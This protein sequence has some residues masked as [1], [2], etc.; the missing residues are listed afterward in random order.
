M[1]KDVITIDPELAR[2]IPSALPE[3]R[4]LLEQDIVKHG[5]LDPLK[6]WAEK[7]ILLDG[8]TRWEICKRLKLPFATEGL[9]FP[10]RAA[11]I[12]WMYRNQLGRRNLTPDQASLLR[13]E[14]YNRRKKAQHDGGKGRSR[15]EDQNDPHSKPPSTAAQ[16]AKEQG[17][18]EATVKRD[19]QFADQVNKAATKD[20]TIRQK[21]M[22]G[23]K[24]GQ[25]VAKKVKG[26]GKPAVNHGEPMV[27]PVVPSKP[28][29][30]KERKRELKHNQQMAREAIAIIEQIEPC[31]NGCYIA[32]KRIRSAVFKQ[33]RKQERK[34][35]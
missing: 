22:A 7:G 28:E 5:C 2:L 21:I 13:G 3:E 18:G 11:A 17:V 30:L 14:L 32:F 26:A 34:Q 35:E 4:D 12:N 20:P 16:I 23:G 19:G 29:G 6:V 9:A 31:S 33:E 10:D 8:H 15:S 27:P 25:E 1:S 24:E